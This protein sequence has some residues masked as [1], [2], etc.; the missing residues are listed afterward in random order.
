V[1][2]VNHAAAVAEAGRA[3]KALPILD[4]VICRLRS[5]EAGQS[6]APAIL[7]EALLNLSQIHEQG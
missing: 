1:A 4:D 2:Q 6:G 3:D 7:A 5:S